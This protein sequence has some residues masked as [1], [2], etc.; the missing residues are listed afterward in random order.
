MNSVIPKNIK[1][2]KV[3]EDSE[4]YQL[5]GSHSQ[6][7]QGRA[8]NPLNIV[9]PIVVLISSIFILLGVFSKMGIKGGNTSA[10]F[11]G[12]LI[13]HIFCALLYRVQ[14]IA[15][16]DKYLKWFFK[17]A[18]RYLQIVTVF[19]LALALGGL[20]AKLGTGSYLVSLT[21]SRGAQLIPVSFFLLSAIISFA[22]GTSGGTFAII[23]PIVIPIAAIMNLHIPLVLGAIISGG[24]LGDH[25]S[26]LS[27]STILSAA[28][29]EIDVITHFRT[30]L[31]YVMICGAI[32][33][34]GFLILGFI[35]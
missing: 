24:V 28:I 16:F 4:K 7:P 6:L 8:G 33:F 34:L 27:G 11:L 1:A 26:P 20:I 3:S 14:K 17:G 18:G 35:L 23:L 13:T 10:V 15:T 5:E 22:T 29:A 12:G 32:S 2:S 31:P 21:A 19:T 9:L 25:S 30:Q